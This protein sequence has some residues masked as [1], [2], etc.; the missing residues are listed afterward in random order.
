[1]AVK[2]QLSLVDPQVP[3]GRI[4]KRDLDVHLCGFPK[5]RMPLVWRNCLTICLL[6]ESVRHSK[7]TRRL[8]LVL[9][10]DFYCRKKLTDFNKRK[11]QR[12]RLDMQWCTIQ[13]RNNNNNYY[14]LLA[15][16][17]VNRNNNED[18]YSALSPATAGAQC[19]Y[20]K[21]HTIKT[22]KH[23]CPKSRCTH[24]QKHP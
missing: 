14:S 13:T 2:V 15:Y 6:L 9:L 11:F 7:W 3:Q 1:M 4:W 19:A 20:K 17:P 24:T 10:G 23:P 12:W 22:T 5:N 18:F 21:I 16:S 8:S